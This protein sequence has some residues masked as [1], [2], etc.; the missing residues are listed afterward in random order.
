MIG[1][2][3]VG[4]GHSS[5]GIST[6]DAKRLGLGTLVFLFFS[7]CASVFPLYLAWNQD[8]TQ[9]FFDLLSAGDLILVA[10]VL[11]ASS[12][13]DLLFM[14]VTKG[15][16]WRIAAVCSVIGQIIVVACGIQKYVSAS[17]KLT[18]GQKYGHVHTA[19]IAHA[20]FWMFALAVFVAWST[21]A[22]KLAEE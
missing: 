9:G 2:D 10:V 13:G 17:G 1:L 14:L 20:S 8:T 22:I 7:V 19:E 16:K 12:L 6:A 11:A 4:G 15:V 18:D 3:L 5:V 21:L